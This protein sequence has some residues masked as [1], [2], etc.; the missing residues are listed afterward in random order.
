MSGKRKQGQSNKIWMKQM[1]EETDKI[2][3]KKEDALNRAK[4]ING[5]RAIAK[6]MG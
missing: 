4:R 1:E 3:L 5:V 6:G 2:C